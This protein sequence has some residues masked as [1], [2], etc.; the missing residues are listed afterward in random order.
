MVGA[1][2]RQTGRLVCGVWA[3]VLACACSGTRPMQLDPPA[4][5]SESAPLPETEEVAETPPPPVVEEAVLPPIEPEPEAEPENDSV[6]IIDTGA[7]DLTKR[8]PTLAETARAE[9][10]RRNMALPTDIVIT[11]KNLSDYATGDLTLAEV[12]DKKTDSSG[13]DAADLQSE[14]AEREAYWRGRALEI[15]QAWRDAYDSIGELEEKVFRL[16]QEFYAAD[17]GF[18]RDSEIK[19]AWDRAIEQLDEAQQEIL[20]RQQELT[21]YLEEGRTAGAFPGWL[22]EGIDL[23]PPVVVEQEQ[24]AESSEPVIYKQEAT[25]PP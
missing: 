6:V 23:E 12:P 20:A 17:D 11:D 7:R 8:P 3:L 10:E 25:D 2:R 24:T 22:R 21:D 19:P 16:R 9:R 13:S 1:S 18:Y 5:T 15:R 14:M 4:G